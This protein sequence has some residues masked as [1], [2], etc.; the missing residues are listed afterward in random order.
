MAFVTATTQATAN[1][2]GTATQA[3]G[4]LNIYLP[5][6][7]GGRRKLG[8][9]PLRENNR[10]EAEVLGKLVENPEAIARLVQLLEI[11]FN[12][13]DPEDKGASIAF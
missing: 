8:S 4:F 11:E 5:T 9:L 2:K 1:R 6:V 12:P 13:Y 3:K 10:T 7:D